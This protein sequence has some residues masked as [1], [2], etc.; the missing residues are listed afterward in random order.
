MTSANL[1]TGLLIH[2]GSPARRIF[3][4]SADG[5]TQPWIALRDEFRLVGCALRTSDSLNGITPDFEIH[6]DARKVRGSIPTFAVLA[7]CR[8]IHPPNANLKYLRHYRRLFTWNPELV[9]RG[10]ATKIQ[11]AHPMGGSR[12]DGYSRRDQFVVLIA[13]NKA[14]PIWKPSLDLY[15]E[16]VLAIRWFERHAPSDFALY[17]FGWGKSA[18]LPTRLGGAVHRLE[19]LL[20]GNRC[21]F[22]SWRGALHAKR[23]VLEGARFSIVY[24]N[25]RG[26]RGYITEKI[27]DA[28]CA[29]NVPIYWGA[30]DIAEYIPEACFIDRRKFSSCG[31][32]YE[33]IRHMPE[34]A[35]LDHQHAIR[36]FLESD[37]SYSF[38]TKHFAQTIVSEVLDCLMDLRQ[39]NLD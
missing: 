17:G 30:E 11:L 16:R 23:E 5:L 31:D 27:F 38:S 12:V 20:P 19:G 21:H 15:S 6:L 24:E 18:R 9:E 35:Y 29:G 4:A 13:A 3:E 26:L 8:F 1:L 2:N 7:E 33:F 28:F 10:A 25:V 14:L 34:H 37:A 32:L 39:Q 22:P 36:D